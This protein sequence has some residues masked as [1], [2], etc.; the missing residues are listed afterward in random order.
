MEARLLP[1]SEWPRLVNT[2]LETAV[3]FFPDDTRVLVVEDRGVILRCWSLP[4]YLH[5]EGIWAHPSQRGGMRSESGRL[6]L[7][8]FFR[9]ARATGD[10]VVL[11]AA[12]SPA[13]ER[14][15]QNF[16]GQQLPGTHW[17]LPIPTGGL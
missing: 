13:V 8:A 3:Q 15:C 10:R 12:A 2:E 4:R 6:L 11:T 1:W 16:G 14:M 9:E 5:A 7:D 17:A